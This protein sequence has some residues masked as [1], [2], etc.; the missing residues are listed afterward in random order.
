MRKRINGIDVTLDDVTILELGNNLYRRVGGVWEN[1]AGDYSDNW[2]VVNITRLTK[3]LD[4]IVELLQ[5]SNE[6]KER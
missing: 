3:A 2:T 6:E 1:Q 4:I 5:E